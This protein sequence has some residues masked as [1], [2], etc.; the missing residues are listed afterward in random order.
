MRV[1]EDAPSA[2]SIH[3]TF[4]SFWPEAIV[5]VVSVD[6]VNLTALSLSAFS[7]GYQLVAMI[8]SCDSGYD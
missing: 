8:S 4:V 3:R 6:S 5:W 7:H 2:Q 1:C